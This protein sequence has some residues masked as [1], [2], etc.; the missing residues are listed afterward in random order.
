MQLLQT[1]DCSSLVQHEHASACLQWVRKLHLN[2][3]ALRTSIH[4]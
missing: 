3:N 1:A 4:Q 2:L